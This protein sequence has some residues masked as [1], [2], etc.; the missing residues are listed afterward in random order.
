MRKMPAIL[1]GFLVV[2]SVSMSTISP[3]QADIQQFSWLPPYTYRGS[4]YWFYDSSIV[5]YEHGATVTLRVP[6]KGDYSPYMNV[7]AVSLVFDTGFN[8]TLNYTANP[9][10]IDYDET[11][12]FDVSFT[13]N[14]TELSNLWAHT[15]TIYVKYDFP[16][17]DTW[18]EEWDRWWP[19]YRFVVFSTEQSEAMELKDEYDTIEA[20]WEYFESVEGRLLAHEAE[21]EGEIGYDDLYRWDFANAKTHYQNG[22]DLWE[23]A[24]AAEEDWLTT[25]QEAMLNATKNEAD[26]ALT[27]ADAA[28]RS[29]DASMNQ[30]YVWILV[31]LGMILTGIGVITYAFKKPKVA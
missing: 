14:V 13:A 8:V 21:V 23:D 19:Y 26:A 2:A 12:L 9:V 1:F 27:E 15:Y 24:F 25:Y 28:A 22:I 7:T 30:F 29:A 16:F 20:Y 10:K 4:E 31:G 6:V 5:G 17:T 3:A 11:H 18:T